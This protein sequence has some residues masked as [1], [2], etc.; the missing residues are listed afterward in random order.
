VDR[1]LG[2]AIREL[3]TGGDLRGKADEVVVLYP[4]GAIPAKRVLVVGLGRQKPLT[5]KRAPGC[6]DGDQTGA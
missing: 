2:G 6:G 5:L 1:A 4:R 3:I